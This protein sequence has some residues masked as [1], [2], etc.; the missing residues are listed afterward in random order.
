MDNFVWS[1]RRFGDLDRRKIN[2]WG[3]VRPN[4]KDMPRDFGPKQLKLKR[5]D[6]RVRARGGLTALVWKERR[7]VYMLI[8]THHQ[9]QEIFVTTATTQWIFTSWNGT[10]G[11]WFT[12]TILIVWPAAIRWVDVPSVRPRNCFFHLLDLTVLN[13]LILLYSCG[14]KYTHQDFRLLLVRSSI[15]EAINSQYRPTPRLVGRPIAAATNV[16]LESR[17]NQHWPIKSSIQLRCRLCS[18]RGQRKGTVYKSVRCDVGLCVVP[19]FAEYHIR[20]NL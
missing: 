8:W 10:T 5:G 1:P 17:H 6:I 14:A 3:S 18:S 4:R 13:S 2:S 20:V 15:E 19:Y 7:D 16:R 12:W 11:T 9:Q